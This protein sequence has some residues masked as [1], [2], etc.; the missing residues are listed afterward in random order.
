MSNT[1]GSPLGEDIPDDLGSDDTVTFNVLRLNAA[2]NQIV[3]D[4]DGEFT[5]TLTTS[6]LTGNR[7]V[8]IPNA[9][10]TLLFVGNTTTV[11]NKTLDNTC[12]V[13]RGVRVVTAAGAV[14][15]TTA[16]DVV[17]VNKSVGAATVVNLPATPA[18]GLAFVI[19]DGK[20]DAAANNITITPAAGNIDGAGTKVLS[21]NYG[22]AEVVY[23]GTEWNAI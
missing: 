18:T 21:A 17:V 3:F 14:T 9:T 15:V 2:S 22:V 11:S 16:D 23:N 12:I 1:T 5:S 8:T 4:A 13:N 6:A 7:T 19:K 20:G 10:G